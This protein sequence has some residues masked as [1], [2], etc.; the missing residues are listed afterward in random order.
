MIDCWQNTYSAVYNQNTKN[1]LIM[2]M[3]CCLIF[4]Y[5]II[6]KRLGRDK[7]SRLINA[8]M[9]LV[10]LML[11]SL[12]LAYAGGM[13]LSSVIVKTAITS[14]SSYAP[15]VALLG[16]SNSVVVTMIALDVWRPPVLTK[17]EQ[18]VNMKNAALMALSQNAL[19]YSWLLVNQN[20]LT[21]NFIN[22]AMP[23]ITSVIFYQNFALYLPTKR[24]VPLRRWL[25]SQTAPVHNIN[26][27]LRSSCA[28]T[29]SC[30]PSHEA[31]KDR[32]SAVNLID[33]Y[34]LFWQ[35]FSQN[36]LHLTDQEVPYGKNKLF[37]ADFIALANA[38][39]NQLKITILERIMHKLRAS[40]NANMN[41]YWLSVFEASVKLLQQLQYEFA[42]T[43]AR[44][45]QLGSLI[46]LLGQL[47]VKY[48]DDDADA[49]LVMIKKLAGRLLG[50][51]QQIKNDRQI[52]VYVKMHIYL[53]I[54]SIIKQL[55]NDQ[56]Y[57]GQN[58]E[59]LNDLVTK[60]QQATHDQ[61]KP[62]YFDINYANIVM[63]YGVSDI[64]MLIKR[65]PDRNY[66]DEDCLVLA[67]ENINLAGSIYQVKL[68]ARMDI[69]LYELDYLD[70]QPDNTFKTITVLD[71]N[72]VAVGQDKHV[73]VLKLLQ[74]LP[75]FLG[76]E[77]TKPDTKAVEVFAATNDLTPALGK[78]QELIVTPTINPDSDVLSTDFLQQLQQLT[79]QYAA[80][81]G[82]NNIM[83]NY[84]NIMAQA[85]KSHRRTG[86]DARQVAARVAV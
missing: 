16:A 5:L 2:G 8:I 41:A 82:H 45:N 51:N 48:L 11:G 52:D 73:Q 49:L 69:K 64:P 12:T 33:K 37:T 40:D 13:L 34:Q 81:W 23:V 36:I 6:A 53:A 74:R 27:A 29:P 86:V 57:S 43:T 25:G 42:T 67:V 50:L 85:S 70:W 76:R 63:N 20:S 78:I 61:A 1:L 72:M 35:N 68:V 55:T 56:L 84:N 30:Q 71:H 15:Y 17:P 65:L 26:H 79:Q 4:G 54:Q 75:K 3:N 83:A 77:L 21:H 28:A 46:H 22:L 47:L 31:T 24:V 14:V 10:L 59:Q 66:Q 7:L 18:L 9:F 44:Q 60:L 58:I 38:P 62:D 39:S 19:L 32:G 80:S